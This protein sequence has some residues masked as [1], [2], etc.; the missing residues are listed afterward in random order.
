M[1]PEQIAEMLAKATEAALSKMGATQ[2]P[3]VTEDNALAGAIADMAK[4]VSAINTRLDT[5]DKSVEK[6]QPVTPESQ[7]AQMAAVIDTLNKKIDAMG[8]KPEDI[9]AEQAA[10][11]IG[12]MKMSDLT[13]TIE[14][15]VV[16]AVSGKKETPKGQGKDS[17]ADEA[18][19][20][21]DEELADGVVSK[22]TSKKDAGADLDQF[23]GQLLGKMSSKV[24]G[25]GSDSEN[26]LDPEEAAEEEGSDKE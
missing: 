10:Q 3:A 16:K 21:I 9:A 5:L 6:K 17:L 23:F 7:I 13:K 8:K 19:V 24:L 15:I 11:P 1:N 25:R 22:D 14:D 2:K 26:G 18:E 12:Q 4:A 20:E